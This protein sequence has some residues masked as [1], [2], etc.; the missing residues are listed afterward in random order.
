VPDA[1]TLAAIRGPIARQIGEA[2]P[3]FTKQLFPDA[4]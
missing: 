3:R 2:Y 4:A 1:P